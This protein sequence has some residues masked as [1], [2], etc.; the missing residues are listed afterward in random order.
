MKLLDSYGGRATSEEVANVEVTGDGR[1]GRFS[2]L[3][4]TFFVGSPKRQSQMHVRLA[5]ADFEEVVA[6]M[7]KVDRV[8]ATKAFATALL[9]TCESHTA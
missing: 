7:M 4:F 5:S 9:K 2:G 3:T 6:L 1:G 8:A